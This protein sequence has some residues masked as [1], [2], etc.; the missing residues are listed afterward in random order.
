MTELPSPSAVSHI[1]EDAEAFGLAS[2]PRGVHVL[3][4]EASASARLI[5]HLHL[6]HD[7]ALRLVSHVVDTF[8]TVGIDAA[9]VRFGAAIHDIGKAMYPD[10][11][12]GAGDLHEAAGEAFLREQG[13][14]AKLAR[15]ARTHGREPSS[16]ELCLE[17][18]LVIAADKVWKGK[19]V[20]G[21]EERIAHTIANTTGKG[22]W[23][24]ETALDPILEKLSAGADAR[25]EWQARF[26]I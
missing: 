3:L 8:P 15:F 1:A 26:P 4:R 12:S 17:D 10:E 25:L 13:I 23:D 22:F 16:R 2:L 19:R 18:L 14:D 5:A 6:V 9:A 24:V 20:R 21:L 7:V 11:L